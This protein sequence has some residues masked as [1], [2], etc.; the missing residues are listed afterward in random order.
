MGG[1]RPLFLDFE[2]EF[3]EG[4]DTLRG[5]IVLDAFDATNI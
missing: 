3:M 4:C 1:F 5:R 2:T